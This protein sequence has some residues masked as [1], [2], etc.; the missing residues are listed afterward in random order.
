MTKPLSITG[1]FVEF[2]TIPV[3]DEEKRQLLIDEVLPLLYAFEGKSST[4]SVELTP[5]KT[6]LEETN[7]K[8]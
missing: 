4:I 5:A 1:A 3:D 2:D 7:A 8:D 6:P